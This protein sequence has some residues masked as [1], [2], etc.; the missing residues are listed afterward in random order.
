[1]EQAYFIFYVSDQRRSADFYKKV[2]EIEPILDVAGITEFE[3][4][5]GTILA[6]MPVEGAARLI[7]AEHFDES[8]LGRSPKAEL[9]LVVDDPAGFHRRALDLGSPELSPMQLRT[10]GHRA[11]YSMDP[12]GHVLA[13]AEKVGPD[14]AV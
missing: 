2:L 10:W 1:M 14:C 4:R 8:G 6:V 5:D 9:Y 12:D 7:G 3:L 11:A 13:F